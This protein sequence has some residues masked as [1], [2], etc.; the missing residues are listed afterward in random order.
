MS[1][2]DAKGSWF[3][4]DRELS[5]DNKHVLSSRRGRHT[6]TVKDV[7]KEDQGKYTFVCGDLKTSASLRMKRKELGPSPFHSQTLAPDRELVGQSGE[8]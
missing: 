4:G 2:E 5:A 8:D 6:L 1:R 3:F 7:K